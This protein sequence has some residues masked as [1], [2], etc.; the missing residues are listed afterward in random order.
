MASGEGW[1]LTACWG[2]GPHDGYPAGDAGNTET[3]FLRQSF[4]QNILNIV[5]YCYLI[6][7]SLYIIRLCSLALFFEIC[8]TLGALLVDFSSQFVH[9]SFLRSIYSGL[10]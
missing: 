9:L 1:A 7:D 6:N 4:I 10:T 3:C 5:Y 2:A 8:F